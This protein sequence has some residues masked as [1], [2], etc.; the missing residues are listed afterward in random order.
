MILDDKGIE[1]FDKQGAGVDDFDHLDGFARGQGFTLGEGVVFAH[2][3]VD[4]DL[5]LPF[6]FPL[7]GNGEVNGT[8]AADGRLVDVDV[9]GLLHRIQPFEEE[10]HQGDEDDADQDGKEEQESPGTDAVVQEDDGPAEAEEEVDKVAE[11]IEVDAPASNGRIRVSDI[12]VGIET[13]ID[14]HVAAGIGSDESH[15]GLENE[16]QA[17]DQG[18]APDDPHERAE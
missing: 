10:H 13:G 3:V 18:D 7:G 14:I 8:G 6:A 11:G 17:G 9:A 1:G 2:G 12:H 15:D 4:G 16:D 5:D